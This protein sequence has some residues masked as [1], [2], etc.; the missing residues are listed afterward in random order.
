MAD[1]PDA[2][3]LR[4]MAMELA[5]DEAP[6]LDW[7]RLESALMS[8]L[9][10]GPKMTAEETARRVAELDDELEGR[11]ELDPSLERESFTPGSSLSPASTPLQLDALPAAAARG[12][13]SV[14]APAPDM[15][16][17][18]ANDRRPLW[19]RSLGLVAVA[20]A[21]VLGVG[22]S[23]LHRTAQ[24]DAPTIAA[25]RWV[26]PESVPMA[27]GMPGVR[28]IDA[29]HVGDV[30][31]AAAGS[32][33]FGRSGLVLS[34]AAGT[35]VKIVDD[36]AGQRV[37][38]LEHGSIDARVAGSESD[39]SGLAIHA[40]ETRL[41]RVGNDTSFVVTRS[42]RGLVVE[43]EAGTVS[44]GAVRGAEA[45]RVLQAPAKATVSLDGAREIRPVVSDARRDEVVPRVDD[46]SSPPIETPPLPVVDRSRTSP[47]TTARPTPSTEASA[48]PD[49]APAAADRTVSEASLRGQLDGCFRG[50]QTARREVAAKEGNVNDEVKV[51]I[52]STL[53][54]RVNGE[55][56]V[57]SGKFTPPLRADL[58]ACAVP[59]MRA[60]VG[61]GA[62][63]LRLP[64]EIG[65]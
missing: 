28:D 48:I 33:S 54:L 18:P 12:R 34:F 45:P 63:V 2:R 14:A 49:D 53:E 44:V 62:R 27:Q 32:L 17:A 16:I 39:A 5:G 26:D 56:F 36:G 35:R 51:A 46:R 19:R 60:R 43:V 50:V 22:A 6:K 40:G 41:S 59:L 31:E 20:A 58:Q 11:D 47:E 24:P 4:R 65:N 38:V 42:S 10:E 3:A 52:R 21:L 37:L 13:D 23:L 1:Q 7:D 57:E 15:S 8:R 9:D 61:G 30:V 29:L 55:G 64:V 25:E